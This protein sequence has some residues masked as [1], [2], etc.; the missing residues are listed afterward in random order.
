M[1]GKWQEAACPT[2]GLHLPIYEMGPKHPLSPPPTTLPAAYRLVEI[3]HEW[4]LLGGWAQHSRAPAGSALLYAAHCSGQQ[5]VEG[6]GLI[7]GRWT[8]QGARA[9]GA[10]PE[11]RSQKG[12][13]AP[14]AGS[15]LR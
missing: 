5:L 8:G 15:E 3:N 13:Q 11:R 9:A 2:R 6:E 1:Q 14:Q 12:P 4:A 10:A 7:P